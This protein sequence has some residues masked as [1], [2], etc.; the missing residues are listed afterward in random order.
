MARV[1]ITGHQR[2]KNSAAW[3]W[4]ASIMRRELAKLQRPL[5][6]VT[7]LAIGADQLLAKLVLE[8]GGTIYAV[9]P[10]VDIERSFSAEDIPAYRDLVSQARVEVLKT[11]GTV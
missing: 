10:Y 6:G 3:T 4:V 11:P 9:L 2:L 5:V 1:G 7:S 8:S